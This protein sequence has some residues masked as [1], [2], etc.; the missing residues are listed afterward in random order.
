MRVLGLSIVT[1]L[2]ELAFGPVSIEGSEEFMYIR[3]VDNLIYERE[4]DYA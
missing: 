1:M 4:T 3:G 2:K